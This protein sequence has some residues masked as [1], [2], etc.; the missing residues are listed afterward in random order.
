[1]GDETGWI[2]DESF[3]YSAGVL[4]HQLGISLVYCVRFIKTHCVLF[5]SNTK[6]VRWPSPDGSSALLYYCLQSLVSR[7]SGSIYIKMFTIIRMCRTM[8]MHDW[9]SFDHNE[10]H[11]VLQITI[12][13]V[14]LVIQAPKFAQ[15]LIRGS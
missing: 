8:K 2:N 10:N 9:S 7:R 15:I 13:I 1:M 11:I 3:L 14:H 12:T 5:A 6:C 4:G